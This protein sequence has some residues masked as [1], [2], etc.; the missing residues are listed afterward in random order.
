VNRVLSGALVVAATATGIAASAGMLHGRE[1]HYPLP[2]P[3]DRFL[4]L[5]SGRTADRLALSFDSLVADVYWIRTIQH[6]GRDYKNRDRTGRFELLEP[7][8]DIT[9]TLDPHFLIAYRFGAIFLSLSPPDGPGRP[10][11]AIA[12]LEKGLAANPTKWQLAHDLAFT[13]YLY[14]GDY[15]AAAEWFRRA[16][17]MPR[18]P[19]WLGPL[20]ATTAASGG[21]RA[22]ARKM[23]AELLSAEEAYIRSAAERT[24]AQLDALDRIDEVKSRIDLFRTK[25]GRDPN[26]WPEMIAAGL[27]PGVPADPS[28]VPFEYDAVG[29]TATFGASSALLPLPPMLQPK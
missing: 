15:Q 16:M 6:Y 20:A 14:T 13:N 2:E 27:I 24:L 5:G 8:L 11:R 18:A 9:T 17:A 3:T 28:G 21:D 4:Y 25:T 29:R 19:E 1:K 26:G 10:D 7:L 12:L 23:L 22:G